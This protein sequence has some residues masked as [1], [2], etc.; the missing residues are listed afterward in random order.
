LLELL[1]IAI[2][3]VYLGWHVARGSGVTI[4]DVTGS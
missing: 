2:E 3:S 1:C 4:L